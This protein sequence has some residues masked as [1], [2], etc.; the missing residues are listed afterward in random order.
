MSL[1]QAADAAMLGISLD[2]HARDHPELAEALSLFK[3]KR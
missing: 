2:D 1:R 3:D